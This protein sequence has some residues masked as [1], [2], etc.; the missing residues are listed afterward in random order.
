VSDRGSIF[1]AAA[2]LSVLLPSLPPGVRQSLFGAVLAR[3]GGTVPA[4][5]RSIFVP[6][7]LE[8]LPASDRA[9]V[10]LEVDG[11]DVAAWL[12]QLP[13][14]ARQA[15]VATMPNALRASVEGAEL[16]QSP[17]R[18]QAQAERGRLGLA[19][20]FQRQLARVGVPFTQVLSGAEP[21]EPQNLGGWDLEPLDD[22]GST[23]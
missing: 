12:S 1:D 23:A 4:W 3:F 8:A 16:P 18:L 14:D 21:T 2:A 10:L 17:S 6:D 15:V 20:A 9:D 5:Y 11:A 7:M 22:D 19:A 13:S